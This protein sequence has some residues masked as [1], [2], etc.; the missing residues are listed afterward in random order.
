MF[1]N[2]KFSQNLHLEFFFLRM[3]GE[4]WECVGGISVIFPFIV[5]LLLRFA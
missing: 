1:L 3:K 2:Y 4:V 5:V